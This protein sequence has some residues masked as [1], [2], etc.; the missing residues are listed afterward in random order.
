M[1]VKDNVE[2]EDQGEEEIINGGGSAMAMNDMLVTV[3]F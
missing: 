2:S 1:V 3:W